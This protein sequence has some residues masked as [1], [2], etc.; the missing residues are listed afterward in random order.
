[1]SEGGKIVGY[2]VP[3]Y[4]LS[5]QMKG[6]K[7]IY[8][9]GANNLY[10]YYVANSVNG[11]PIGK[12]SHNLNSDYIAGNLNVEDVIVNQK[13]EVYLSSLILDCAKDVSL[14][15]GFFIHIS[16]GLD[17]NG[18]FVKKSF[19]HFPFEN[20]RVSKKDDDGYWNFVYVDDFYGKSKITSRLNED[21]YYYRYN[22]SN[23]AIE[24]QIKKDAKLRG[25]PTEGE[26]WLIEAL[27]VY[28]GQVRFMRMTSE[29]PYPVSPVDS[30][31]MDCNVDYF[32]SKYNIEQSGY[33]FMGK[34]VVFVKNNPDAEGE[35]GEFMQF[36]GADNSGGLY[37]QPL[38]DG[39]D[40][41]DVFEI[42]TF[43]SQ[44]DDKLQKA[45]HARNKENIYGAFDNIPNLLVESGSGALFGS[46]PETFILA[47]EFYSEQTQKKREFLNKSLSDT[48]GIEFKLKGYERKDT[49]EL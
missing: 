36:I 38:P 11:S 19:T 28:R 33:G 21:N 24:A 40:A 17:E 43:Q 7:A 13:D 48:L 34:T 15:G 4:S 42:K 2:R 29:F 22:P 27:R 3:I 32:T 47:K 35:H 1:M 44:F 20:C 25:L 18:N 37:I 26:G 31:L 16:Y 39:M 41:G 8:T 5:N 49:A 30:V 10:P 6:L 46:N 14:Q 23:S 45:T 9:N 12:R